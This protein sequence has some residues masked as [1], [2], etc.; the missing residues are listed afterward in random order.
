MQGWELRIK[1]N[2][3]WEGWYGPA[4]S[5]WDMT[6]W[7]LVV[8]EVQYRRTLPAFEPGLFYYKDGLSGTEGSVIHWFENEPG[9]RKWTR[10]P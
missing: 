9:N 2:G 3:L 8:T 5:L 6:N 1:R 7:E 10:V 4:S